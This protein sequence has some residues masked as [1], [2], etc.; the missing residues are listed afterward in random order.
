MGEVSR[1]GSVIWEGLGGA[2]SSGGGGETWLFTGL[3]DSIAGRHLPHRFQ[4]GRRARVFALGLLGVGV[5]W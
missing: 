3:G 1:R 4:M 2:D 5:A